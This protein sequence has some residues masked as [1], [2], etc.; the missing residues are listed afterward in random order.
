MNHNYKEPVESL[1]A[2]GTNL[3]DY[4]GLFPPASLNIAQAFNN[5]IMYLDGNYKWMLS[6]FIIPAKKLG[7]LSG[8]MNQMKYSDEL[9]LP[10]SVL[11]SRGDT[12]D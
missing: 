6:R 8:L 3:I 5:F 4:A 12:A 11:G 10:F 1:K 9:I 2:F 7:E